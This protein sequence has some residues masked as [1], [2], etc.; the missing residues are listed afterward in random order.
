MPKKTKVQQKSLKE[1]EQ[2]LSADAKKQKQLPKEE[3]N[4]LNSKVFKNIIIAIAIMIYLIFINIGS[5]NIETETFITDLKVFS[6]ILISATVII[7][8]IAYKKDSGTLCVY[9]IETLVLSIITLV[10][11][12]IYTILN[13]KFGAIVISIAM[14]F[15][16]Y[17]VGKSI[18]IYKKE[19]KNYLKSTS[20][21]NE[22]VK[23]K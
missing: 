12:T 7:F 11:P 16:V 21:I 13:E 22:I 23:K 6:I 14:L 15:A 2:E 1:I 19:K 17:Y 8:E 20:D 5:L 3:S 4:K 18:I 9:G 10:L